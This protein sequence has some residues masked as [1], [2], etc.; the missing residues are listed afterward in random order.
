MCVCCFYLI[1]S[2]QVVRDAWDFNIFSFFFCSL[3]P[4][5][6]GQ[7]NERLQRIHCQIEWFGKDSVNGAERALLD[8]YLLAFLKFFMKFKGRL[9]LHGTI[10]VNWDILE[11]LG[12]SGQLFHKFFPPGSCWQYDYFEP[13]DYFDYISASFESI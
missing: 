6:S 10:H 4:R 7:Y 8:R 1:I 13:H 3:P 2:L 9:K 12:H 5:N 11:Q